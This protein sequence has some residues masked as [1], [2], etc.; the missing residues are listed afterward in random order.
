MTE[1]RHAVSGDRR[2]NGRVVI[3]TGAGH[4]IGAAMAS[5]LAGDGAKVLV[6]DI[7]GGSASEISD[8]IVRGG[9]TAWSEAMDVCSY[10]GWECVKQ[11][12]RDLG[13]IPDTIV[14]NAFALKVAPIHSQSDEDWD[15]Q[16]VVGLGAVH[17]SMRS[18]WEVL[19]TTLERTGRPACML[20]ISS[21]HATAGYRGHAAYASYKAGLLALCRQLSVEYRELLRVNAILPGAI[22]TRVWDGTAPEEFQRWYEQITMGRIGAPDDIAAAAASP[23][24]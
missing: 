24:G 12:L 23:F 4:G 7:D 10:D 20:L 15:R 11:R 18:M 22:L 5:R 19:S 16:M 14:H 3:V 21:I 9:G 2:L 8:Q 6:A 1:G 17:R 13:E